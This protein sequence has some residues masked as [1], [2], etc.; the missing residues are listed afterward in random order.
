MIICNNNIKFENTIDKNNFIK[1]TIYKN[2]KKREETLN[3]F[4]SCENIQ[5]WFKKF[6][7]DLTYTKYSF[8]NE[9]IDFFHLNKNEIELELKKIEEDLKIYNNLKKS[10]IYA[11]TDFKRQN[12][13]VMVLGLMSK[14]KKINLEENEINNLLNY[15]ENEIVSY[16]EE[17]IKKHSFENRCKLKFWGNITS[18]Y[19][20]YNNN[21]Y[22]FD[23]FGNIKL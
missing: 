12:Q 13:S 18:Y 17:K 8:L 5:E 9:I 14:L 22:F 11:Q 16:V 15:S 6:N 7:Y 21:N 20:V 1:K 2:K 3:L 4:L 10:V 23:K 19:F